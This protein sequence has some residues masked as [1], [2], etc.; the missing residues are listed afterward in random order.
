MHEEVLA[1]DVHPSG[2]YMVVSF[3]SCLRY[4]NILPG[5]V[6]K[7]GLIKAFYKNEAIKGSKEIKFS[8]GGHLFACNDNTVILIF[9]FF[10]GHLAYRF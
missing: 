8:N 7:T 3:N 1:L 9:K 5:N 6:K 10:T 2:F 4:F